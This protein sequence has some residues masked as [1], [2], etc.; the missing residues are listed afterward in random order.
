MRRVLVILIIAFSL[1]LAFL[2]V[3]GM[4]LSHFFMMGPGFG[5]MGMGGSM[6]AGMLWPTVLI[7]AVGLAV[8]IGVYYVLV[9]EIRSASGI[10]ASPPADYR[11]AVLRMLKDD[12]RRVVEALSGT[13]GEGLQR[14]VQ[15]AAG[16]SKVKTHRVVARLAERRLVEVTPSGRTNRL[17]L[18]PWLVGGG[19]SEK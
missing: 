13:G 15:R 17:R 3:S 5:G 4:Y 19:P 1:G 6:L 12:E 2:S 16:F 18:A 8:G 9:P 11:E 14:D 10:D 7:A